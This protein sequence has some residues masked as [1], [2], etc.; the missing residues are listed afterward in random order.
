MATPEEI[1]AILSDHRR[2]NEIVQSSFN[3]VDVDLSGAIDKQELK[4]TM[5]SLAGDIGMNKPSDSE[6]ESLFKE[7]DINGDGSISLDEFKVL[8]RGV[9][10]LMASQ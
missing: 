1:R 6:V 5:I 10:E 4:N 2:F 9:L 3:S 7:L 8:I